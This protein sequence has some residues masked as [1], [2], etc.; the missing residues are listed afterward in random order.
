MMPRISSRSSSLADGP[1]SLD[2]G[3]GTTAT[4]VPTRAN[5]EVPVYCWS[6]NAPDITAQ[7]H[8]VS[9][10]LVLLE[11]CCLV[12][13]HRAPAGLGL[14]DLDLRRLV[15]RAE[16]TAADACSVLRTLLL[17][18]T[19]LAWSVRRGRGKRAEEIT[20]KAPRKRYR[21][22][23][24]TFADAALL[25]A[26]TGENIVNPATGLVVVASTA[27]LTTIVRAIAGATVQAREAACG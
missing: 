5:P 4:V 2:F 1:W 19:G 15:R 3:D 17:R 7:G 10:R 23:A 18:R 21:S 22:G 24:M 27:R 12:A 26:V 6:L 16:S 9:Q 11:I 20:V 25:A 14:L 8:G 13:K